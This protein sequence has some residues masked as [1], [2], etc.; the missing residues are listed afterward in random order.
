VIPCLSMQVP[1]IS[2]RYSLYP[3][4]IPSSISVIPSI[5]FT[6][7]HLLRLIPLPFKGSLIYGGFFS[8][9]F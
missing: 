8:T 9:L 7:P 4:H 1:L 3:F 6:S 2:Y 5:L